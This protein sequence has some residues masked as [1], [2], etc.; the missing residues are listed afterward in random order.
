MSS[1]MSP[2]SNL[3]YLLINERLSTQMDERRIFKATGIHQTRF[4]PKGVA[5]SHSQKHKSTLAQFRVLQ[6]KYSLAETGRRI[7]MASKNVPQGN[8]GRALSTH[9]QGTKRFTKRACIFT[10]ACRSP[11]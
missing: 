2:V 10:P 3:V 4:L 6:F 7:R 8:S 11:R 1:P 9:I 5:K